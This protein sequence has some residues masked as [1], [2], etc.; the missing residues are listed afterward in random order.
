M[1]RLLSGVVLAAVALAAIMFL[2]PLGLRIVAA[3]VAGVAAFEYLALIGVGDSRG[4][5][6]YTVMVALTV[7]FTSLNTGTLLGVL[8]T[9]PVMA[10]GW[11][12]FM[13]RGTGH[14][15]ILGAFGILYIGMPLGLL[16]ALNIARGWRAT[17]LLIA[18]VV[19]SDS[20]QFYTGRMFGRHALAPAIS[21]KK[22]IEGA[23]GGAI[24][25]TL[26]MVF[27]G[28]LVFSEL[29]WH[30]LAVLGFV[31]VLLGIL[32]DLFESRLKRDAHVKDSSSLIPGHGGVLD[33][34]DALLFVTPA[35]A[36]ALGVVR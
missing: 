24:A 13:K 4:R 33:R 17:L 31:M 30:W 35:F 22:T 1:T 21:P 2:P 16:A 9:V 25:G 20:L 15:G 14:Q 34:I 7:W 6:A 5:P 10:G 23:I 36:I 18:T 11:A 3:I 12:V 28:R 19:V 29:T 8:L 32:G 27:V 26:F